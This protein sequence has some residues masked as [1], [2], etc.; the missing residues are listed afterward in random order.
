LGGHSHL[1][2]LIHEDIL[3]LDVAQLLSA[4]SQVVLGSRQREQ[5]VP[6][7]TLLEQPAVGLAL[8]DE[9]CE[10]VGVVGVGVLGGES[11]TV[12]VPVF[13]HRPWSCL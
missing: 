5:H 11:G 1:P 9:F 4:A 10:S 12:R 7:L 3:G 13:P 6:Q 8:L 2:V